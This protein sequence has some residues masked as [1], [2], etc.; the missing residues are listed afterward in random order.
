MKDKTEDIY[1]HRNYRIPATAS[2]S[3]RAADLRAGGCASST[4]LISTDVDGGRRRSA[5]LEALHDP[6]AAQ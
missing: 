1:S 6:G 3:Q 5:H 4:S 2:I